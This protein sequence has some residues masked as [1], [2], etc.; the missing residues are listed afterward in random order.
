[1]EAMFDADVY[2]YFELVLLSFRNQGSTVL[3][4]LSF[5]LPYW[6]HVDKNGGQGK[7]TQLQT[8]LFIPRTRLRQVRPEPRRC[9][10]DLCVC[11]IGCFHLHL[12][13]HP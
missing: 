12:H 4:S 5:Y 1:M 7:V 10:L 3:T 9:C 8:K 13:V 2:I 11:L 6:S